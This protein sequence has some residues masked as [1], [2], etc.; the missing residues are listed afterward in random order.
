MKYI[1]DTNI[2]IYSLQNGF[3]GK[4]GEIVKELL[5]DNQPVISAITEI[6]LLCWR[7][8]TE[9][10]L[11]SIKG[12]IGTSLVIELHPAVKL[13]TVEIRKLHKIKLPDAIIAASA[14][15]YDLTLLTRNVKDF[16]AIENLKILNPWD[17]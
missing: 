8:A 1:W 6:E 12:F 9:N 11:R 17:E 2:A 3:S 5:K 7:T 10:D 16:V 13:Q 15:V 14:L 4:A